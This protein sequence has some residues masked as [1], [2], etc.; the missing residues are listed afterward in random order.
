MA[1]EEP[2][3]S[4]GHEIRSHLTVIRGYAQLV[5]RML[6]R[7]DAPREEILTQA[8]SLERQVLELE[9]ASTRF[10][11]EREQPARGRDD[12]HGSGHRGGAS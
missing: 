6:R 3:R 5:V 10:L 12:E 1:A 8:E 7:P 11:D 9:R 4:L 2:Q